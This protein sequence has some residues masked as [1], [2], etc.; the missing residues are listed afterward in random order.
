MQ[1]VDDD[2][3]DDD[4]DDEEE[5]EEEEVKRSITCTRKAAASSKHTSKEFQLNV[6]LAASRQKESHSVAHAFCK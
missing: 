2:D 1:K 6:G 4:D 5:E 3:N